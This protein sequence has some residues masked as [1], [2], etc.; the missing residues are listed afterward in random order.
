MVS[1]RNLIAPWVIIMNHSSWDL[2]FL[3]M[4]KTFI[5]FTIRMV[6]RVIRSRK[7]TGS[8]VA[9]LYN[10]F[11]GYVRLEKYSEMR[12]KHSGFLEGDFQRL[13]DL[14]INFTV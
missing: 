4:L 9:I 12:T 1:H 13:Y 3:V 2:A 10:L 14:I 7:S 8:L 11:H 5:L 6:F